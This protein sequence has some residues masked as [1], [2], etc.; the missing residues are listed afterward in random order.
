MSSNQWSGP[1]GQQGPGPQGYQQ[2]YPQPGPGYGHPPY[3]PPRRNNTGLIVALVVVLVLVIGGGIA[4]VVTQRG[5]TVTIDAQGQVQPQGQP[6][7]PQGQ[8]GQPGQ[9]GEDKP[10]DGAPQGGQPDEGQPR[11]ENQQRNGGPA[12]SLPE[13]FAGLKQSGS[14]E[15]T[16]FYTPE[17]G[18]DY[19]KTIW[20]TPQPDKSMQDVG[21]LPQGGRQIRGWACYELKQDNTGL[22]GCVGEAHGGVVGI[23][24]DPGQYSLEEIAKLG[25]D[26]L[27]VWK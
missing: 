11:P 2:G 26:L 27:A 16:F 10:S 5:K 20:V 15:G 13:S 8:P 21:P 7:Q 1:T 25:D 18:G 14:S 6:G 9:Q 24:G 19:A 22:G 23:L 17:S 3:G 12:P 4:L